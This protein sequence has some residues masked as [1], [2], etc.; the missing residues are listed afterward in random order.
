MPHTQSPVPSYRPNHFASVDLAE[1]TISHK[2]HSY[3]TAIENDAVL[4]FTILELLGARTTLSSLKPMLG[5]TGWNWW[6][7]SRELVRATKGRSIVVCGGISTRLIYEH[8]LA[9]DTTQDASSETPKS[10]II[11]VRKR[12]VSLWL[13]LSSQKHEK[14]TAQSSPNRKL[15][16]L[17]IPI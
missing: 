1:L 4:G 6:A 3:Q 12:F 9:R 2:A 7:S 17:R 8:R 5:K 11:R 15:F 10:L 16:F 13:R 14:P